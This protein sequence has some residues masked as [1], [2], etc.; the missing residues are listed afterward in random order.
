MNYYH[1][2]THD[3]FGIRKKVKARLPEP[4]NIVWTCP[5]CGLKWNEP[6]CLNALCEASHEQK[7]I[8]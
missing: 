8:D 2:F 4:C 5:E 3:E 1:E 7:R 6:G